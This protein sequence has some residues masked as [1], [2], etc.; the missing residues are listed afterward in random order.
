M[1]TKER[2]WSKVDR[3]GGMEGC[4]F[5]L[6]YRTPRGYGFF[7]DRRKTT[8]VHRWA[9]RLFNGA[10][11]NGRGLDHLCRVR[12]CVNP[13]H[14][15]PVTNRENLLRGT[16]LPAINA[17]K[18]RCPAGHSDYVYRKARYEG[19]TYRRCR[20]CHSTRMRAFRL[21]AHGAKP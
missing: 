10:I 19:Q 21:A 17:R 8:S 5:W 6:G 2:F 7:S 16:G 12:H 14:L 20:T 4:W 9:W 3:S 13:E 18:T 11:P 15:E 1:T